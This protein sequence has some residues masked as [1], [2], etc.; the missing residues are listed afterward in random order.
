MKYYD[1]N[2]NLKRN[3]VWRRISQKMSERTKEV[4]KELVE[5]FNKKGSDIK[6]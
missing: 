3:I 4:Y 5:Y 6:C 1:K 2:K